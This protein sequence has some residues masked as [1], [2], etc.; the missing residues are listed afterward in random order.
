MDPFD[1]L[2]AVWRS[3]F[4]LAWESFRAGS[5]GVGAVL[6]DDRGAVVSS[7]RNRSLERSGPQGGVA[8]SRIAHAELN[9]LA[10]VPPGDYAA[11]T[12]YTTLE[13]CLL[14]TAALRLSHVGA[15]RFA[16]PDPLWSGIERIPDLSEQL[17]RRW[18]RRHGPLDGPLRTWG[19][20]LPLIT[21]VESA[22][23]AVLRSHAD[24]MPEVLAVARKWAGANADRLRTADLDSAWA[25]VWPDIAASP[26]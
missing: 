12:L 2:E 7:G 22:N 10:T 3:C 15:V 26:G 4:Q 8:G 14:C 1:G 23:E 11:H 16:A 25:A 13:P 20:L 21:A 5:L 17:S 18:T 9:A 24:T 19:A 6:V